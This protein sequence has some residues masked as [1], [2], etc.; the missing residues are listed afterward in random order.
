MRD[1]K[2]EEKFALYRNAAEEELEKS[3]VTVEKR[4]SGLIEAMRYSLLGGGK[5]IRAA[6]ALEFCDIYGGDWK[7]ALP[8]AAAIE[9]IHAYS[10]I[11]DDMPCMDNDDF[12][13]GKPSCHK[14]FGEAE[15]LL[16]GD[17]LLTYAFGYAAKSKA[18]PE[19]IV[20]A[21]KEMSEFA[22][23]DGMCGGQ[24]I[25]L[26]SEGKNIDEATLET[27]HRLKTGAMIRLSGRIGAILGGAN[28]REIER[29]DRYCAKIGLAFQITDDILD[30][31]G[32]EKLLGK[33]VKSDSSNDKKT[34]ASFYGIEA[35]KKMA[36]KLFCEAKSIITEIDPRDD[37]LMGLTDFLESRNH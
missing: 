2:Y 19:N 37:F 35:A 34:Y 30:V 22:G 32:D 27:M 8:A 3:V 31:I 7:N 21:L 17:A 11:H 18:N 12:R 1:M 36:D 16:A 15:A 24:Y 23:C 14:K 26:E 25:D 33:P 29:A 5:R 10:L 4:C 13:R 20:R 9:M 28:E 6:L